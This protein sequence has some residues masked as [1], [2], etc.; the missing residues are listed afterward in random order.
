VYVHPFLPNFAT[1]PAR[2]GGYLSLFILSSTGV[3]ISAACLSFASLIY[4][5][6]KC[7]EKIYAKNHYHFLRK[8]PFNLCAKSPAKSIP[9]YNY[10]PTTGIIPNPS[11]NGSL[12]V[13]HT[14][15]APCAIPLPKRVIPLLKRYHPVFF[16]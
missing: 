3:V 14:C 9:F 15:F 1:Y 12:I 2:S 5:I 8:T 10:S 7:D 11:R 4:I 13:F 6:V 16:C